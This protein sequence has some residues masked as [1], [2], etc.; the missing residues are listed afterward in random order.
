MK[1][2]V[3]TCYFNAFGYISRRQNYDF[4]TARLRQQG[5]PLY[6]I[7]AIFPGQRSA[8]AG[9]KNVTTVECE[10]VLW[11]KESLLNLLI[12]SLPEKIQGVVWCDADVCFENPA[13]FRRTAR[14]LNRYP[15]VHP[16]ASAVRLP[17]G[18]RRYRRSAEHYDSFGCVYAAAPQRLL[19]G[20]FAAH[21]HTG[22]AWAARRSV[23]EVHGLYDAM[24]AG[25][26][27]H[28]MAHAFAGDFDSACIHRM[29]GGNRKHI[30]HFTA[31]ARRIYPLVRARIGFAYPEGFCISGTARRKT[32]VMSSATASSPLFR[33]T[34]RAI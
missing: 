10:S 3:V 23:L 34:P 13:W 1:S 19:R 21:G 32:A 25:S 16:Y 33:S 5:V 9:Y 12:R 27:D 11:Q 31:W 7:E 22:F 17:R 28:V 14:L 18:V 26:G 4:F 30:E 20:D 15:V 8:L 24:I 6:T 2:A 29:L